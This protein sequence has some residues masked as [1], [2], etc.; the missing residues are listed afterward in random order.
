M[1][2]PLISVFAPAAGGQLRL[3]YLLEANGT[4]SS[5]GG[6]SWQSDTC[7]SEIWASA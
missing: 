7:I 4:L 2:W 1:G 5:G 3:N 6:G